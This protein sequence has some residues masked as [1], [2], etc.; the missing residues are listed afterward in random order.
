MAD[1]PDWF[2]AFQGLSVEATSFSYGLEADKPAVPAVSQVYLST[3]TPKLYVCITAG[4]WTGFDVGQ[5]ADIEFIIDGGGAVITTGQKGHLQVDF[6][7]TVVAWTLLA[8]TPGAIVVDVWQD[9]YAN[10]PPTNANAMPGAGNEPTIAA[11]NQKGRSTD[12]S[13]WTTTAIAAGST[14]AFNVDSVT[15]ITRA[16][17]IL[18]VV[19]T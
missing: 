4:T 5:T 3:D 2:S 11:T 18:K 17:L 12:V 13:A 14:L 6:A 7:C 8:D 16:T 15:S 9:T 10:P 19:K 1:L